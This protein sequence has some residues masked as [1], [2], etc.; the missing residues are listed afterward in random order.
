MAPISSL[1]K[2]NIRMFQYYLDISKADTV[3]KYSRTGGKGCDDITERNEQS[4]CD[5]CFKSKELREDHIK[6]RNCMEI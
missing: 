6:D 5:Q 1:Q 4:N 2:V 3:N